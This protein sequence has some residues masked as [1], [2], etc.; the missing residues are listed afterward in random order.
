MSTEPT[1]DSYTLLAQP[2]QRVLWQ[3]QWPSLRPIQAQAVECVMTQDCD[4]IISARTAAGKTEAAFLPVLSK[5][6]EDRGESVRAVYIGPLKALIND[7]FRRLEDLCTYAEIPVHRWHG[8]VSSN[9]KAVVVKDPSG[10]VLITPESLESLFV[11]RAS[12]MERMF[13]D[14]EFVVID[15]LHAFLGCERGTHLRSL[16]YRLERYTKRNLRIVGLSATLGDLNL[17]AAWVNREDPDSVVMITD[18]QKTKSVKYMIHG[19]RRRASTDGD[20]DKQDAPTNEPESVPEKADDSQPKQPKEDQDQTPRVYHQ[21][22]ADLFDAF[23][24]SRNMIFANNKAHLELFSTL[25]N[26]LCKESGR[27]ESFL[28]HHGSLSKAHREDTEQLMRDDRPM[29]VLCSST[30]EMGID[31][32]SVHAVGQ[33]GTPWSVNSLVQRLGRSGRKAGETAIMRVYVVEDQSAGDPTLVNQLYPGLLRAV[34]VTELMLEKWVEPPVTDELDLSTFV[35]QTLSVICE[36][37]G[38]RADRLYGRLI[39]NGAF[40]QI[41]K[42]LFADTLRAIADHDLIEQMPEGDLILG[43]AGQQLVAD[44]D[45]YSAFATSEEYRVVDR[46]RAV[47]AVSARYLPKAGEQVMLG[48]RRWEITQVD[49]GRKEIMVGPS[50]SAGEPMRYAGASGEI[51]TMIRQRMK[52]A[53]LGTQ[54]YAYLDD[55][56]AGMLEEARNLAVE[57]GLEHRT[58]VPRGDNACVWF[59][60]TGTQAQRTLELLGEHAG[61]QVKDLEIALHFKHSVDEVVEAYDQCIDVWPDPVQLADYIQDKHIRKYDEYLDDE[62]LCRVLAESALDPVNAEEA[63]RQMLDAN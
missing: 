49:H 15:E 24:D 1:H 30:L 48:G 19:Y 13:R 38:I 7:Q 57:L 31:I 11:N 6:V 2:I 58:I 52:E 28:V 18:A 46:G 36:T 12:G 8:D 37:G 44:Y 26:K 63:I 4:L 40:H 60:W 32:G 21:L 43:L 42:D 45:F 14:L 3:M 25:L 62:L 16:L 34:A 33:V 59:T 17:S 29:S 22:A 10:V 41:D 61:L 39:R 23:A 47:G 27:R 9:R 53:L 54:S 56:A 35:Q 51:H 50:M 55:T 5:I 20:P